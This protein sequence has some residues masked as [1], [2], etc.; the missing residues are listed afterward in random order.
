MLPLFAR[1][2]SEIY[3]FYIWEV[4][5]CHT[6]LFIHMSTRN[7]RSIAFVLTPFL[8][9]FVKRSL[10]NFS[11]WATTLCWYHERCPSATGCTETSSVKCFLHACILNR[12]AWTSC[13]TC[14]HTQEM[15]NKR[16]YSDVI[17][18]GNVMH[19]WMSI[20]YAIQTSLTDTFTV[21]RVAAD[22]IPL[23]S[24]ACLTRRTQTLL[25]WYLHRSSQQGKT[26][27]YRV[28]LGQSHLN[29]SK[30]TRGSCTT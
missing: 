1:D 7:M 15:A 17:H 22:D 12:H 13:A 9:P 23:Q 8:G 18:R 6:K 28:Q 14:M 29:F 19:T 24:F 26:T 4:T 5:L 3:H 25:G 16:A 27:V 21:S 11:R 10:S 2:C 30:E 20:R